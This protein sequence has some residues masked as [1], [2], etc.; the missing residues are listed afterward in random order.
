MNA[1]MSDTIIST[2]PSSDPSPATTTT[3]TTPTAL[4]R[5]DIEIVEE[6][7]DDMIEEIDGEIVHELD[8]DD[9][10]GETVIENACQTAIERPDNRSGQPAGQG[11]LVQA[12]GSTGHAEDEA[13]TDLTTAMHMPHGGTGQSIAADYLIDTLYTELRLLARARLRRLKPGQT[14]QPTELVHE[15]YLRLQARNIRWNGRGHFFA[16]AARVM[17]DI[18]V[19]HARQRRSLKRGGDQ[20]RVEFTINLPDGES[21]MNSNEVLLLH[22]ALERMHAEYNEYAELVLMHYFGGLTQQQIADVTCTS[23]RTVQR[24]MRFARAWLQ[25]Y[26]A[27]QD[28]ARSQNP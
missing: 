27:A 6:I 15:A 8:D 25:N 3:H 17:R 19:D 23:L 7:A 20:L 13:N 4:T 21:P 18:V 5:A 22:D 26:F 1:T 2:L 11:T 14:L 28:R 24:Q 10:A 12:G 16:V 9:I